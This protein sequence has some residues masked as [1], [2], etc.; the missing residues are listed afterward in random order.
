MV[1][2]TEEQLKDIIKIIDIS[3]QRGAFKAIEMEGVGKLYI[4]LLEKLKI[5]SGEEKNNVINN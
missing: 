4:T 2:I 5:R 1:E 3:C